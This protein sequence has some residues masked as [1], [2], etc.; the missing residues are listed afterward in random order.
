RETYEMFDIEFVGHPDLRPLLLPPEFEGH[1]LRKD[2][3]L[4][5]RVAK[6]W[7]GA[8]EPGAV[9]PSAVDGSGAARRAP[10]RPPGVPEPGE[11]GGAA[12][13][14]GGGRGPP[15]ATGSLTIS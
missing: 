3:V 13:A 2:F 10:L 7:P 8:V 15:P 12:G 4:A 14:G 5:S 1:P 11:W 9:E 6:P